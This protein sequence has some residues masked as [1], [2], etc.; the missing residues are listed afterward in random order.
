MEFPKRLRVLEKK[1][2]REEQHEE[3]WEQGKGLI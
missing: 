1:E 2:G 3:P